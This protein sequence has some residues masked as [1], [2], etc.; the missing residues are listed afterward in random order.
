[1]RHTAQIGHEIGALLTALSTDSLGDSSSDAT[2]K[3]NA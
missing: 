1:M 2:L 3:P